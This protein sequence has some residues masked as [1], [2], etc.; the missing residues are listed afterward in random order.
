M[1]KKSKFTILGS[2]LAGLSASYHLGHN[3]C[4]I[5]EKNNYAGGHI[6]SEKRDGFTWDIGPHVSFTSNEYVKNLF[7]E[8]VEGNYLEQVVNVSNYYKGH[9][10]PHP[11]QTNLWA[12]PQP[13]RSQCLKSFLESRSKN[14]NNSE[15]KTYADWLDKSYG[16]VFSEHFPTKYTKKYWACDPSD[17]A[18]DWIGN[19][20]HYPE[21]DDVKQGFYKKPNETAHYIKTIRYPIKGGYINFAKNLM[22]SSFINFNHEVISVDFANKI[23]SFSNGNQHHYEKLISTI[24][25]PELIKMSLN[26]PQEIISDAEKLSCSE[27]L[28]INVT[29]KHKAKLP[30]HW[31][32][33]YDEDKLSTRINHLDLLSP[34]N[35][36]NGY[37]GLQVE[38]YSSK[39]KK[40]DLT[41]GEIEKKV[42]DELKTMGLIEEV[43]TSHIIKV[44]YANVIFDN[45]RKNAQEKIFIFLEKFGLKREIDD[46]NPMTNW[47][48]ISNI[49]FGDII[50]AGRYGQWKYF[51]TDDCVLRGMII[52]KSCSVK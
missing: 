28:L 17:L 35:V 29:A 7:N 25:L 21:V 47:K 1:K 46:L 19:R 23:I 36:P 30:Y 45:K 27:L 6:Y 24:P 22:R 34:G 26:A 51:W 40:I 50:L 33:I 43:N 8:S 10:I 2:G 15:H 49:S 5:F 12:V 3:N 38:V 11:A 9:W 20:M 42:H 13:L 16:K 32:Y 39:Y 44:P 18:T 52:G 48:N 37:T 4:E 41:P 31:M 14:N